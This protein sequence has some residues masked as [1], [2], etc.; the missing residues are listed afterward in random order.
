MKSY[1][2]QKVFDHAVDNDLFTESYTFSLN[3]QTF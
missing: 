3:K 2:P 1:I